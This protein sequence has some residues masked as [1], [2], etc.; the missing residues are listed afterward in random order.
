MPSLW[1]SFAQSAKSSSQ[2]AGCTSKSCLSACHQA[3]RSFLS[4][5]LGSRTGASQAFTNGTGT[6]GAHARRGSQQCTGRNGTRT[7]Q[8]NGLGYGVGNQARVAQGDTSLVNHAICF[9]ELLLFALE[10][11]GL[12]ARE[13]ILGILEADTQTLNRLTGAPTG[14]NV[15]QADGSLWDCNHAFGGG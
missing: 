13:H 15:S 12:Q 8:W 6:R 2:R 7:H 5:T 10:V 4:D 14:G 9:G 11:F 1:A 3:V